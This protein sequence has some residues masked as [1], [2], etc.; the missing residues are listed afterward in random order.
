MQIIGG[1]RG[2]S[3]RIMTGGNGQYKLAEDH[4][5]VQ[6]HPRSYK[7]FRFEDR[8]LVPVCG[9]YQS[10]LPAY[11]LVGILHEFGIHVGRFEERRGVVAGYPQPS[12]AESH[13]TA[14]R[15]RRECI[16]DG[17]DETPDGFDRFGTLGTR[18]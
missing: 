9:G 10:D 5:I 6:G 1:E 14:R 15:L 12:K 4:L 2:A 17:T 11:V 16:V 18:P 13:E 3:R 7:V 8:A